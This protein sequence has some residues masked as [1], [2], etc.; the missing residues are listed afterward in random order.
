M[1]FDLEDARARGG[2]AAVDEFLRKQFPEFAERQDSGMKTN[3]TQAERKA[4]MRRDANRRAN[5]TRD[6]RETFGQDASSLRNRF[7]DDA[8][9]L[10]RQRL[11]LAESRVPSYNM[12]DV[13]PEDF[14]RLN[15]D[16]QRLRVREGLE[17]GRFTDDD[18]RGLLRGGDVGEITDKPRAGMQGGLSQESPFEEA[19]RL[20]EEGRAAEMERVYDAGGTMGNANQQGFG[21]PEDAA[22]RRGTLLSPN[23]AASALGGFFSPSGYMDELDRSVLQPIRERGIRMGTRGALFVNDFLQGLLDD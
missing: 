6:F 19:M 16:F 23:V 7:G 12:R 9:S 4:D 20:S 8:P 1:T 13:M 5:N 18:M 22:T 11:E 15:P 21:R 10:M 2:Q 3:P 17:A 14:H